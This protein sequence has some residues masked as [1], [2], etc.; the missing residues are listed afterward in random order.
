[1]TDPEIEWQLEHLTARVGALEGLVDALQEAV[2]AARRRGLA[3][4]KHALD[5]DRR[6]QM[7]AMSPGAHVTSSPLDNA[8]DE[9]LGAAQ[10]PWDWGCP[11]P[12][13]DPE[14]P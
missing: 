2:E 7:H 12:T 13:E 8:L 11:R 10:D 1:M 6:F 4:T 3:A 5:L 14:T 9:A